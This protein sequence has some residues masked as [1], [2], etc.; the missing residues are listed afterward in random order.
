MSFLDRQEIPKIFLSH[1][2]EQEHSQADRQQEQEDREKEHLELE[3]ALGTLKAFSFVSP[4]KDDENLNIHRLIQLVM[5]KW[6]INQGNSREW[7]SKALETVSGLYPDGSY[8]NRKICGFYLP[9]VYAVLSHNGFSSTEDAILRASLLNRAACFMHVQGKFEEAEV[10][11]KRALAG[12]EKALEPDHPDTLRVVQNLGSLYHGRGKVEEA[13][14][15]WKRAL[16]GYE[17]ALEP[18]H[19]DT[20]LVVQNLGSLYHGRGKVEE[21]RNFW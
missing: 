12:Y 18:D 1:R 19:P 4:G 17:K 21:E 20:L 14:V 7:A 13:E 5:R 11:G 2:I 6:L 15:M 3:K 9:H 10:M 16:A 8:E